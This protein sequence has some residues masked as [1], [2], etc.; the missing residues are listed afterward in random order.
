MQSA[1]SP[2]PTIARPWQCVITGDC[3]KILSSLP[4]GFARLVFADP[5]YNTGVDYG[6]GA[7]ADRLPDEQYLDWCGRWMAQCIRV[8]RPDGSLWVVINDEYVSRFDI[9]LAEGGLHRRSWIKWYEKFG[10]N[11]TTKFNR[12]SRHVLYCVKDPR[13]FVFNRE[14]VTRQSDRQLKYNDKRANPAGKIWDDVWT[15]PRLAGTHKER[16][17][18]FPTQLPLDLLRPIIGCASDPD[19][20]V[21]D[22]FSGSATTG[23]AAVEQGRRYIGIESRPTFAD[24]SRTRLEVVGL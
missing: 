13:R 4:E 3:L 9:L 6:D 16:I 17:A 23:V 14:A 20:Y 21:I 7:A 11:C 24:L 1:I 22:P 15:I 8:L 5:P 12:T 2:P 19:D 10:T 18:G